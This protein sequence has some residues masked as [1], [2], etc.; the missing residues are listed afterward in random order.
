MSKILIAGEWFDELSSSALYEDEYEKLVIQHGDNLFPDYFVVPFKPLVQ[1]EDRSAKPDLALVH[2]EYKEWWVVEVE[3]GRHSFNGHVFPQV[4]TLSRGQY[5]SSK[6]DA[7]CKAESR[8]EPGRVNAMVKGAQPRVLV[9][10]DSPQLEWARELKPYA[11]IVTVLQVF[12]SEKNHHALRLNGEYPHVQGDLVTECYHEPQ[13][14]RLLRVV[15]P[16]GLEFSQEGKI[17]IQ[18]LDQVT[19]WRK[20]ESGDAVWLNPDG[21]SPLPPGCKY[22][23]VRRG[24]GGLTFRPR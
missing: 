11:A 20:I 3:M 15:S 18:L 7:L 1:A 19:T 4:V 14:P 2:K 10:V 6:A 24:S 17:S 22:D 8:L 13:L 9:L 21:L 23:I 5:D 12:R 16:G